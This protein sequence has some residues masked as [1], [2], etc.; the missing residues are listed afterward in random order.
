MHMF[1][2]H[3]W[4]RREPPVWIRSPRSR[5]SFLFFPHNSYCSENVSRFL[6]SRF[7]LK[8]KKKKDKDIKEKN[9][10]TPTEGWGIRLLFRKTRTKLAVS[11]RPWR[12][13]SPPIVGEKHVVSLCKSKSVL[14][15]VRIA[16]PFILPVH[17]FATITFKITFS[18]N[19]NETR[20]H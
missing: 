9:L 10:T 14:I 15:Y 19:S 18:Q 13:P 16:K 3:Y 17:I 8:V 5:S 11:E 20:R 2:F 1:F 6:S 12:L 4:R 7:R